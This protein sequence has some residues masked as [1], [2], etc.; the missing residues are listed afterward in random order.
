MEERT[1]IERFFEAVETLKTDKVIRGFQT[2]TRRYNLNRRNLQQ[3]R[4]NP[5]GHRAMMQ[6]SW[7]A[8]LV[9][10]YKVNPMW[11]LSSST[12]FYQDGWNAELVR[13]IYGKNVEKVQE[14]RKVGRPRKQPI[15]IQ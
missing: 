5:D 14:K 6:C 4:N 3:L 10:D 11:L 12:A 2:F 7:L 9:N 1:I 8:H 13:K 15:E